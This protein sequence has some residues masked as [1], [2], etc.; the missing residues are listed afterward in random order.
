MAPLENGSVPALAAPTGA[1]EGVESSEES[2]DENLDELFVRKKKAQ[3]DCESVVSTYSNLDNHPAVIS[4]PE[5]RI[6]LNKRGFSGYSR[7]KNRGRGR[8]QR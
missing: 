8:G 1:T 6:R 7:T 4:E 3:W 2:E 5:T